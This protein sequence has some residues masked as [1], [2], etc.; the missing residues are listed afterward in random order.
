MFTRHFKF[1]TILILLVIPIIFMG[2]SKDNDPNYNCSF[3]LVIKIVPEGG[4]SVDVDFFQGSGAWG[5]LP[6]SYWIS[7][8]PNEGYVFKEWIM[9]DGKLSD[10]NPD[11]VGCQ[12][13]SG[14]LT[15]VFEEIVE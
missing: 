6:S 2:C 11:Q 13:G 10:D 14:T 12:E 5:E 4:G 9:P 8:Q 3:Q 15:A 1:F 7:A